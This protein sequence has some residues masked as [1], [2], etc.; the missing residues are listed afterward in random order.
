MHYRNPVVSS[1]TA[2]I[3]EAPARQTPGDA[4]PIM[5]VHA[6]QMVNGRPSDVAGLGIRDRRG[7]PGRL[8]LKEK[9]PRRPWRRQIQAAGGLRRS[10]RACPRGSCGELVGKLWIVSILIHKKLRL[11]QYSML[12]RKCEYIIMIPAVQSLRTESRAE[13]EAFRSNGP[14]GRKTFGQTGP[15][16]QEAFRLNASGDVRSALW[17]TLLW[18]PRPSTW[19]LLFLRA[20]PGTRR[21]AHRKRPGAILAQRAAKPHQAPTVR[22]Q[23]GPASM[24]W[25]YSPNRQRFRLSTKFCR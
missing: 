7:R 22:V 14:A 23:I 18:A 20:C 2:V 21:R 10:D 8:R 13:R 11:L 12:Q 3:H 16:Y 24:H 17:S 5:N 9:I 25:P 4:W 6:K 1:G 19:R 15:M